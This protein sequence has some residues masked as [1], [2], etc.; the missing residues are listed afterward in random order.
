MYII[1]YH[2][3]LLLFSCQ[4][5]IL[6]FYIRYLEI[7]EL[8]LRAGFC[9]FVCLLPTHTESKSLVSLFRLLMKEVESLTNN[10]RKKQTNEA[11]IL[12]HI[13]KRNLI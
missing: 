6:I 4:I 2:N 8:N 5:P 1:M 9:L 13:L 7:K 11:T 10:E 12:S 3:Y